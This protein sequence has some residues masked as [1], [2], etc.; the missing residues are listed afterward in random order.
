MGWRYNHFF[1][2]RIRKDLVLIVSNTCFWVMV[3]LGPGLSWAENFKVIPVCI[4]WQPC[5]QIK[6]WL[7]FFLHLYFIPKKPLIGVLSFLEI[8]MKKSNACCMHLRSGLNVPYS[9]NWRWLIVWLFDWYVYFEW[10]A[11][12]NPV[13]QATVY[14]STGG[15]LDLHGTSLSQRGS[16]QDLDHFFGRILDF[17]NKKWDL[18]FNIEKYKITRIFKNIFTKTIPFWVFPYHDN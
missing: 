11:R 18:G 9:A 15:H 17:P 7:F 4:L 1:I 10:L 8:K 5:L 2:R 14:V 12:I 13:N 6:N 16:K 3:K